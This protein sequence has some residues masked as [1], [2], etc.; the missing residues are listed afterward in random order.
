MSERRGRDTTRTRGHWHDGAAVLQ[1]GARG[2]LPFVLVPSLG[3]IDGELLPEHVRRAAVELLGRERERLGV[4]G[5]QERLHRG[6]VRLFAVCEHAD[7][8]SAEGARAREEFEAAEA[9]AEVL[10]EGVHLWGF[11]R[12]VGRIAFPEDHVCVY[13]W[14]LE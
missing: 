8:A 1:P 4:V 12:R 14:K 11:A 3:A 2:S 5:A 13:G 9:E 7:P 10:H 6:D